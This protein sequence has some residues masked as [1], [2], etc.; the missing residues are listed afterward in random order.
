MDNISSFFFTLRISHWHCLSKLQN[1]KFTLAVACFQVS[2]H[3]GP[4]ME[5]LLAQWV[6]CICLPPWLKCRNGQ[7][8]ITIRMREQKTDCFIKTKECYKTVKFHVLIDIV[9]PPWERDKEKERK[10]W[11]KWE[12]QL[13]FECSEISL[14]FLSQALFSF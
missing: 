5:A 6:I 14:A 13:V 12:R 8:Q 1:I 11:T 7:S 10:R 4:L 2:G 9:K 3:H